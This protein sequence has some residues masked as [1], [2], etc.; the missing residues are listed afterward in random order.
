M[1]R[2]ESSGLARR[3][4]SFDKVDAF[5]DRRAVVCG[6]SELGKRMPSSKISRRAAGT[7]CPFGQDVGKYWD[8]RYDLFSKF[9]DGIQLDR[10]ALFSTKPESC[11]LSI[12]RVLPGETVLDGLC[13]AGGTAIAFA[14]KGKRVR[15]VDIDKRKIEMARHNS[16]IY[17]CEDRIEFIN[18]DVRNVLRSNRTADA[19]YFDPPWGGPSYYM[20]PRFTLAD[21]EPDGNEL[22]RLATSRAV[23]IAFTLPTNFDI[24]EIG[25]VSRKY[26]TVPCRLWERSLFSTAIW[27][28]AAG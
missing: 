27:E 17:G 8:R 15:A 16:R 3:P 18:D 19:I 22:I 9:D 13:G 7:E 26:K 5:G 24:S 1:F 2:S 6:R 11:A 14:R 23:R 4:V 12:A 28:V 21:F 25:K 20:K 10:E